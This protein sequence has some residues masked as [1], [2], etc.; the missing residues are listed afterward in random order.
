MPR[1]YSIVALFLSSAVLL[2]AEG[3]AAIENSPVAKKA[4]EILKDQEQQGSDFYGAI[5]GPGMWPLWIC[6]V[7][8]IALIFERHKSLKRDHIIDRTMIDEF[9]KLM[10][11]RKIDDARNLAKASETVVGKAW[12]HGIEEFKLGGVS[13][14]DALT[15]KTLL[16]FKPLKRNLQAIATLGVIS[17]LLGLLGTVAGMIITFQQIAATGGADKASLADGIALA[18]LTTAGGLIVAIP[19]IISGRFFN[20]RL[21]GLAEEVEDDIHRVNYRYNAYEGEESSAFSKETTKKQAAVD[22]KADVPDG[23]GATA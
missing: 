14:Q 16:A 19:A 21:I 3:V 9:T 23:A 15:D 5:F 10:S 20:S 11:E 12:H 8:L 13:I 17:P 6:S 1:L 4:S 18:L 7:V 22:D 2:F